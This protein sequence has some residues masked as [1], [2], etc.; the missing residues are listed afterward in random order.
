MFVLS[1][2]GSKSFSRRNLKLHLHWIGND[3]PLRIGGDAR[4]ARGKI[5]AGASI[6]LVSWDSPPMLNR[7]IGHGHTVRDA[8]PCSLPPVR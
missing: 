4:G 3:R 7:T 1:E 6:A 5:T 2:E 8:Q